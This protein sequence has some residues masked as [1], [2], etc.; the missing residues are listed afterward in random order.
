MYCMLKQNLT[1]VLYVETGNVMY[2][3][4]VETGNVMYVL[5]VETE[6]HVCT[7]C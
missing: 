3:L 4:Y 5:Y 7:V 6:R 2:V 1:Y